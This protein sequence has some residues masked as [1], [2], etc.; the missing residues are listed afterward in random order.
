MSGQS[1]TAGGGAFAS[2]AAGS[3]QQQQQLNLI[4]S[5]RQ[6]QSN[7]F[8]PYKSGEKSLASGMQQLGSNDQM[9]A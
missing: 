6:S 9:D 7:S 4:D 1:A 3:G 5:F 8:R 2:G